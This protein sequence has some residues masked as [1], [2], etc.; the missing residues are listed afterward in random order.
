MRYTQVL[1]QL[2]FSEKEIIVYV[3]LLELDTALVRDIARKADINRTS[4]YDI[5]M[6]LAKRGMIS[7]VI[8]K[9][10]TYR[11]EHCDELIDSSFV[12]SGPGDQEDGNDLL[13]FNVLIEHKGLEIE[14]ISNYLTIKEIKK[15]IKFLSE[16][17]EEY[18]NWDWENGC[19]K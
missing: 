5:L 17:V 13:L 3:S 14:H 1:E 15:L 19:L 11:V 8:K 16:S 9:K 6:G 7:K 18:E 2:G 10:K 4:C 12:F